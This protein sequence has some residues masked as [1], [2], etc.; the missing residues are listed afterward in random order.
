MKFYYCKETES[1]IPIAESYIDR[2]ALLKSDFFR[3][4]GRVGSLMR[5]WWYG[6]FTPGF[7]YVFWMRL[8]GQK[9][10]FHYYAKIR[11]L[12]LQK[13]LC[14]FISENQK[15]GWGFY[16]GHGA[17]T[18]IN[19]SVI[20]G[21]NCNCSQFTTIGSNNKNGAIIGDNVYLGPNVCVV[22][23]VL[24]HRGSAIG[25]GAVVVSDVPKCSTFAG[26]PAKKISDKDSSVYIQNPWIV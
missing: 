8:A 17:G 16:L 1:S 4:T 5:M 9:G 24:I 22:E 13:K 2:L 3:Y 25:A 7:Q 12:G 19:E 26:N 11:L 23:H 20:I 18:I 6:L 14:I 21:N 15:I 10:I